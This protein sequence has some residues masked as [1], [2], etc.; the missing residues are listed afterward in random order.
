Y[1]IALI[2]SGLLMVFL[3]SFRYIFSP[4]MSELYGKN[5]INGFRTVY[6]SMCKWL[7]M[8]VFPVLLLMIFFPDNVLGILFGKE[9]VKA[10]APFIIL[11]LGFFLFSVFGLSNTV[12]FVVGKTKTLMLITSV[13]SVTNLV[14]N[15]LLIPLIGINGA[16]MAT[17]ISF[18]LISIMGVAFCYRYTGL[19]PVQRVYLKPTISGLAS[20]AVF[21]GLIK[22]VIA[23][24]S[25]YV[26]IPSLP[27]FILLYG[28]L[29]LAMKGLD[30]NDL[31]ILR[32]L[33]RKTGMRSEFLRR[34]I[35]RFL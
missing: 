23:N 31:M 20:L 18:T 24:T 29:I 19:Y 16:A 26:L 35:R 22:T 9:A 30:K 25:W 15:I 6:R 33:E 34:I 1:N 27:L 4:V 17:S 12:V 13:C 2:T 14:L 7:F 11:S 32:T 8:I 5:N 10:S 28:F 3:S 21:Y